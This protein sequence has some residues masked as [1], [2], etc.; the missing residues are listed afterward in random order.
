MLFDRAVRS[1]AKR[2]G[3]RVRQPAFG[4]VLR[5]LLREWGYSPATDPMAELLVVEEECPDE[6]GDRTVLTLIGESGPA[7]RLPLPLA[8]EDLWVAL[9]ARFHSPPR[10]YIRL[11]LHCPIEVHARGRVSA[12]HLTSL[13]ELGGRFHHPRE[14]A[15]GETIALKLQVPG[16]M[17]LEGKVIYAIDR[18]EI[19]GPDAPVEIGAVFDRA[20]PQMRK[21]LGAFVIESYFARIR[22]RLDPA[23]FTEGLTGFRPPPGSHEDPA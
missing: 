17:L 21:R 4:A 11:P 23:V 22:P 13:S 7:G 10:R 20:D 16:P 9:G 15:D 19:D 6:D 2:V 8:V 18:K 1:G 14:L 12:S 3:I 5:E